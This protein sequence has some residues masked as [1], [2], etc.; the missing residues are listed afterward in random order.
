MGAAEEKQAYRTLQLETTE[1]D[2]LKVA[3]L[4]YEGLLRPAGGALT[5]SL[6]SLL[7]AGAGLEGL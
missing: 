4:A 7:L 3:D 1:L 6:L 2:L 5:S